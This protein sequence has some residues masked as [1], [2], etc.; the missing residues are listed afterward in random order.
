[1][2]SELLS[3]LSCNEDEF[4]KAS[5]EYQNVLKNSGFKDKLI[6]TPYNQYNRRQ[7]NRK[8]M[9]YNPSFNLQVKTN[10]AKT[11][12][13]S[14]HRLRKIINRNTVKISYSCMHNM[15]S[16]IFSHNK[17]IIQESKKSQHPN[18]KTCD[19]QVAENCLLNGNFKQSAVT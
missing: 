10:I 19:C 1:M 2:T 7:R 14:N 16:H 9:W 15:A 3:N 4:I 17:N 5:G 8:V 18:P 6:Y 13:S 12:F 11:F